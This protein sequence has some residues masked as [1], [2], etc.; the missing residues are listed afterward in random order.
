VGASVGPAVGKPVGFI[1]ITLVLQASVG[2]S[3]G[4]GVKVGDPWLERKVGSMN[5]KNL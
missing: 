1:K 3:V 5:Y 2:S 4:K